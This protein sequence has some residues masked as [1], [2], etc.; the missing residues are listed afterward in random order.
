LWNQKEARVLSEPNA[1]EKQLEFFWKV[2]YKIGKKL[3]HAKPNT[4]H[5]VLARW[6]VE[7]GLIHA[8]ITQNVDRLHQAAGSQNVIELHGNAFESTCPFCRGYYTM[9]DLM[10]KYRWERKPPTCNVCGSPLRPNVILFGEMIP[11]PEMAKA[12]AEVAKAD[13]IILIGSSVE[14]FPANYLPV[15][16][17]DRG[18]KLVIINQMETHIDCI[19]EFVANDS[20]SGVLERIDRELD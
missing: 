18:G 3:M 17:H 1:F 19:A 12:I 2:G 8:I 10:A 13:L 16:V 7:R 15:L 9:K 5:Q 4:G 11:K 14:V 6:E 20:I